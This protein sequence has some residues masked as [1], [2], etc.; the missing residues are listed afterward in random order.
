[1]VIGAFLLGCAAQFSLVLSGLIVYAVRVPPRVVG[2]IAGFGVGA[3]VSAIAFDLIPETADLGDLETA[4][5]LLAG[6]VIYLVSDA[7]VER[8]FGGGDDGGSPLGIVVGAV[9][10]GIPESLI[11]GIQIAAGETISASLVAAVWVSNIPQALAPSADLAAAGWPAL[12]LTIMWSAVVLACG[13]AAAL[14]FMLADVSSDRSGGI[15]AAIAAGGLLAMITD[16]LSPFAVH[17]GG[18][19]AGLW[20]VVGFAASLA[21]D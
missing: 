21:I 2:A 17:K 4:L 9:V 7:I 16:S 18:P 6:A 10:D 1:V 5:W 20:T 13:A 14:G 11:F 19:L 8:R 12:R 15:A 3:L